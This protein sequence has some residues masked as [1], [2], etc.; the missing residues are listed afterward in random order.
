MVIAGRYRLTGSSSGS[1][2][3]TLSGYVNNQRKSYSYAANIAREDRQTNNSFIPRLW[4]ARKIGYLLSQIRL[5]GENSEW[6]DAII[7]LSLQY[8]IITPYTSFLIDEHDI[9]AG[10]GAE[11]AAKNIITEFAAPAFGAD[12]VDQADAESSLR[13]AESIYQPSPPVG[14]LDPAYGKPILKYVD[15]KTFK[16]ENG[17]WVDTVYDP[18]SME[19][20]GFAFGSD[21]YFDL[22]SNRP[23]WGKYMALGEQVIFVS[24]GIAYVIGSE[25]G[26]FESLPPDLSQPEEV[27]YI[28]PDPKRIF[29]PDVKTICPGPMFGTLALL[30]LVIT[31][32]W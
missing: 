3:I 18:R 24:D 22:L 32:F 26:D 9:L 31:K 11:E 12:A 13:S 20:R 1:I 5:K 19:T 7:K 14:D 27:G 17:I 25:P 16:L 29:L 23:S 10:E 2:D 30:G 15:D 8:G 21:V 28:E 4:A 6:V